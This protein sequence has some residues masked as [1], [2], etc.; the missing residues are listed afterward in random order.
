MGKLVRNTIFVTGGQ[1]FTKIISFF[2]VPIIARMLGT[3]G[4]GTYTLAF[5][6]VMLFSGI[7]DLG[8]ENLTIRDISRDK[9]LINKFLSNSLAIRFIA[10]FVIYIL[11]VAVAK[12]LNY[13]NEIFQLISILGVIVFANFLINTF[14]SIIISMERME[15]SSLIL[16]IQNMIN[17]LATVIMLYLEFDLRTIFFVIIIANL[18]LA[19]IYIFLI[20]KFFIKLKFEID[21][22]YWKYLI[23]NA[24][25]F[26]ILNIFGFAYLY[27]GVIILSKLQ[28]IETLGIFNA[29]YKLVLALLFIPS[30][31]VVA[32]FPSIARQTI[33]KVKDNIKKSCSNAIR[34]LFLFAFPATIGLTVFSENIIQILYGEEFLSAAPIL[35]ILSWV[36]LLM[37]ITAPLSLSLI[38]SKHIKKLV[39]FFTLFTVVSV[40]LNA[41]FIIKFGLHGAAISILLTEVVRFITYIIFIK[42]YVGF[43]VDILK[44]FGKPLL[45]GIIVGLFM[46]IMKIVSVSV[47][48]VIILTAVVYLALLFWAKEYVFIRLFNKILNIKKLLKDNQ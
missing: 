45:L 15:I 36:M 38:N 4:F 33:E 46:I 13:P 20:N 18:I 1:T 37:F 8:I 14:N 39:H 44:T 47:L 42:K 16:V 43:R 24:L 29:A 31:V 23:V 10:T 40:G 19:L 26:A 12:L 17:P 2:S 5:S 41:L 48:I 35:G 22:Y 6:F 21:Y 3:E 30:S 7:S 11:I 32:F 25:P 27:N 34:V 28:G 9:S